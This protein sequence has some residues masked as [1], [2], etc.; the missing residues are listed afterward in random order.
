MYE[1]KYI[2]SFSRAESRGDNEDQEIIEYIS[3]TIRI[4]QAAKPNSTMYIALVTAMAGALMFGID[5]TNF[6]AVQDFQSFE[7]YWY[8]LQIEGL[9][10]PHRP[11]NVFFF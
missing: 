9:P 7:D 3:D 4:G 5:T 10:S 1:Y 11:L 6:G 8:K 2:E